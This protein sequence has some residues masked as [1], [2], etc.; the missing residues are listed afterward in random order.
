[1]YCVG[2]IGTLNIRSAVEEIRDG[3]GNLVRVSQPPLRVKFQYG[4]VIPDYAKKKALD[5]L[6][7]TGL[8][9]HADPLKSVTWFDSRI[10][11]QEGKWDDDDLKLVESVLRQRDGNGFVIVEQPRV[12]PP[13][14]NWVKQTTMHGQRKIEHVVQAAVKFVDEM[15]LNADAVIL[16]EQ[17]ANRPESAAIIEAL[18]TVTE[19]EPEELVAA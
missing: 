11:A 14:P 13:F 7:F 17:Q 16:F 4:G 2:R 12:E 19:P 10:A 6:D 1:M 18:S 9:E 15:G 5:S 8:P 3:K